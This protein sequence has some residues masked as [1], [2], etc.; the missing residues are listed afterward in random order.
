MEI[1]E[2][3]LSVTIWANFQNIFAPHIVSPLLLRDDYHAAVYTMLP[4]CCL[5]LC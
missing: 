3:K 5:T 1:P 2:F 4:F